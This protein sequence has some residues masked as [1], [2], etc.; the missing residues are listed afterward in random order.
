MKRF[1]ENA[2]S[3]KVHQ[4]YH[5]HPGGKAENEY[6]ALPPPLQ[7][8]FALADIFRRERAGFISA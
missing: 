7:N 6:Q 2:L 1:P 8:D 3:G 5:E 4:Q